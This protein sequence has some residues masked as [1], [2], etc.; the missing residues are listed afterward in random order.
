MIDVHCHINHKDFV[1]RVDEYI[2]NAKKV[3]VT[4]FL[5]SGWD[6]DSSISAAELSERYACVYASVGIHPSDALN[7]NEN[8]LDKIESLII[9][10]HVIAIGEI[11]LDYHWNKDAKEQEIQKEFFIKQI[12]LANKHH[13]PIVV[14]SRDA[15]EETLKILEK[16]SPICGGIMHC[17]SGG[18]GL[19]KNYLKLGFYISLGGPVTYKNS[20]SPKEVAKIVPLD[21]ILSETDSPYLSPQSVRGTQNESK[22]IP[23]ILSEIS[24]IK[25][26]SVQELEKNINNNFEQLFHVK[27]NENSD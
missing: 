5:V 6:V 10:K 9:R 22:N 26:I 21:K 25:G 23:L 19:L 15:N 1:N 14:H 18:P 20:I 16:Y 12:K 24:L 7:A 17:Y 13:L 11:G 27:T 3:G 8:D 4:T 2:N